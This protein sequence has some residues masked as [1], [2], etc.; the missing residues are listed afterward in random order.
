[1][2]FNL[3]VATPGGHF[4]GVADS[5]PATCKI[6]YIGYIDSIVYNITHFFSDHGY[7]LWF[8]NST[9]FTKGNTYYFMSTILL[10][11]D[12]IADSLVVSVAFAY[13]REREV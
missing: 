9:I 4:R 1:M 8:G 5:R 3:G 13:Q 7:A 10:Y 12:L 2:V 11:T 6:V